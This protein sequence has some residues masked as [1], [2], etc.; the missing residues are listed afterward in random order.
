LGIK[1][2]PETGEVLEE[3]FTRSVEN[4]SIGNEKMIENAELV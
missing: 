2:R 4:P 1:R 3:V